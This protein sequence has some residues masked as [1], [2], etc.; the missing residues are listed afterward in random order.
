MAA[1]EL[2]VVW[3]WM[4]DIERLV[5]EA[6]CSKR[7]NLSYMFSNALSVYLNVTTELCLT[8]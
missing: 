4:L 2:G 1:L 3:L 7:A 8:C 6:S 5:Y